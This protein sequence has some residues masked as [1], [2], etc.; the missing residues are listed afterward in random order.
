MKRKQEELKKKERS[1][2]RC[3]RLR[4]KA[5]TT[6]SSDMSPM[7][8]RDMDNKGGLAKSSSQGAI[9]CKSSK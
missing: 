6:Q 9:N 8:T 5:S 7:K 4:P 3:G 2:T 1:K